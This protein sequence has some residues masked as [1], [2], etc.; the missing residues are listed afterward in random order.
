MTIHEYLIQNGIL[1]I[2]YNSIQ[3]IERTQKQK[4]KQIMVIFNLLFMVYVTVAES[5]VLNSERGE[6]GG[7]RAK[8]LQTLCAACP[9]IAAMVRAKAASA[10]RLPS[11]IINLT[12]THHLDDL[13]SKIISF[14]YYLYVS[15][16]I[17]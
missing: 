6:E 1:H 10:A 4:Q 9:H 8:T 7:I 5:L 12:L 14:T 2:Y 15:Y 3:Q 17:D 11:L 13:V 16:C